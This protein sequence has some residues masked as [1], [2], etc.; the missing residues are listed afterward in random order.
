M[1]RLQKS[2][3]VKLI[4][5]VFSQRTSLIETAEKILSNKFGPIDFSSQ[6]LNFNHTKYYEKEFGRDLKRKFI[7]FKKLIR[8]EELWKIKV[9][10]NRLEEKFI[11]DNKRQINIDPGYISLANLIL[12]S[13]KNFSHRIYIKKCIYQEV[14]LIFK[15]KTFLALAWTYPD[16]QSKECIDIFNQIRNALSSQ[17]K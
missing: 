12:A 15:D 6:V 10:T 7:S 4:V 3:P 17:L 8:P 1:G 5:S 11:K 16:Y 13:T 2:G 14:T 9:L